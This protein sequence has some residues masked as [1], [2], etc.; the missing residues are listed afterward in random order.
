MT[1]ATLILLLL[2]GCVQHVEPSAESGVS[3]LRYR[4]C[5]ALP[6][7]LPP[8]VTPERLRERHDALDRLYRDCAERMR[9]AVSAYDAA[10]TA[11]P[12]PAH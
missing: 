3:P 6:A 1:R 2:A 12:P 7:T 8:V 10:A 4:A 9:Q 5:Q 11:P